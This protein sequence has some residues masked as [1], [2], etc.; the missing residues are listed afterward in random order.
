MPVPEDSPGPIRVVVID[1]H[2]MMREGIVGLLHRQSDMSVVGEGE[3]GRTGAEL[4]E[5]LRPDIVLMDMQMPGMDGMEAIKHIRRSDNRTCIIVL[6]TY[7]GDSQARA[8]LAA[9]ANGYLLKT[10]IRK[11]LLDAIRSAHSGRRVLSPEVAHAIAVHA[12]ID[13]LTEREKQVLRGVARGQ[14]NKEIARL[15]GVSTD[16]VKSDLKTIFSKLDVADRT[17]AVV[18]ALRRGELKLLD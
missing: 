17:Q 9:G 16:T 7:P 18:V 6:T 14:A 1:D 2:P 3:D 15:I 10:C 11:D 5:Q 12:Y 4:V 13:P 8:A